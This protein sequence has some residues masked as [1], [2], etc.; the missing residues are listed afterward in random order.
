MKEI[1]MRRLVSWA[2]PC[3]WPGAP[4]APAGTV[5]SQTSQ[6]YAMLLFGDHGYDLDY[7][8]AD[9]RNPPL[10]LEQAVAQSAKNGPRTRGRRP[11]LR[12]PP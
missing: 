11:N 5:S 8:E 1:R 6:P 9:E 4:A 3:F 10:T 7:L 2:P 12:R